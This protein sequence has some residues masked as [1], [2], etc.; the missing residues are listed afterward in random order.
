MVML[1]CVCTNGN[2]NVVVCFRHQFY[3]NIRLALFSGELRLLSR[4]QVI[5]LTAHIAQVEYGDTEATAEKY[6]H[7][8][9]AASTL[10][11]EEEL[12]QHIAHAH[13]ELHGTHSSLAQYA[14][15]Q[16]AADM[17]G[18]GTE[19][20]NVSTC[21][22]QHKLGKC[23]LNPVRLLI[24]KVIDHSTRTTNCCIVLVVVG[25]TVIILLLL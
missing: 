25:V 6:R 21:H 14:T 18:Y 20:F 16:A 4:E 15:L 24:S 12:L 17:P 10:T 3:L 5:V 7:L 23:E 22:S 13:R 1:L 2:G 11:D 9:P 19:Y 8:L